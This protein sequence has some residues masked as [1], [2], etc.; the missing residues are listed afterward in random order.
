M[1]D[2]YGGIAIITL[3]MSYVVMQSIEWNGIDWRWDCM[4]CELRIRCSTCRCN[5]VARGVG[6]SWYIY[7][8][9]YGSCQYS[10]NASKVIKVILCYS[11]TGYTQLRL[12]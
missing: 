6:L 11:N 8:C 7:E 1:I 12:R 4:G 5:S 3:V 2:V 10:T 9:L